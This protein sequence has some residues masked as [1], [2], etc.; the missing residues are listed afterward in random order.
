MANGLVNDAY[1]WSAILNWPSKVEYGALAL[2]EYLPLMELLDNCL[3]SPAGVNAYAAEWGGQYL[4]REQHGRPARCGPGRWPLSRL[5]WPMHTA[6][7]HYASQTFNVA[8]R[9]TFLPLILRTIN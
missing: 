3:R 1:L 8:S 2:R 4:R 6:R 5:E 7:H 9:N